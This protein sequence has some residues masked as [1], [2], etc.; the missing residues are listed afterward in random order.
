MQLSDVLK[1]VSPK[2]CYGI[3]SSSCGP[4]PEHKGAV[5]SGSGD[6]VSVSPDPEISSIHYR[7]QEVQRGGLFVAV[8]GLAADGHDFI[9]EAIKRGASAIVVQKPV[10]SGSII[11]EVENTR[12]ALASISAEFFNLPSEKLFLIGITGTNGKTTTAFLIERMFSQ[13]G[14]QAG[15]IGTLNYRYAGKT[16]QN[17]M[18]TPE[19]YDLQKILAEMLDN[20]VTHV[21]MEVSSHALD[22]FRVHRCK[23]DLAIFTNLTQDHLDY[24]HTMDEYWDCKKRL[25]TEAANFKAVEDRTLFVIN[26]NDRK[27]K[28]LIRILTS[29]FGRRCVLSVGFSGN[30]PI[31]PGQ[32]KNDLNG[33]AGEI[34]TP[35][36]AFE[37]TSPLVGRHNLENILCAT[38]AGVALGLSVNIIKDAIESVDAV[39]GRL[40]SV[41]NDYGR[42]VYVDYAHTP[43]ALEKVLLSLR[44]S[45]PG[46]IICVFG[47]GGDR[48]KAKRPRMGEVAGRLSDLAVITSDN[49]RTE[50][51]EAIIDQIMGGTKKSMSQRFTPSNLDQDFFKG[52][53]VEPDRRK[54]ILLAVKVSK[55]NDAILIAG[56]GNEPYQII[57]SKTVAFDDRK[58]AKSALSVLD[59]QSTGC[60]TVPDSQVLP[61]DSEPSNQNRVPWKTADIVEATGGKLFCGSLDRMFTGISIDSRKI[62]AE[63]L[64]LALQG[65]VHDGHRFIGG[66]IEK[67][68][69]GCVVDQK[70]LNMLPASEVRN[71]GMVCIT[72]GDTRRALGDLAAFHRRRIPVSVVAITGSNGKTTTRKM[73]SAVV[74]RRFCTLSTQ[75]NLNNDI[76]LP[77]TLLNLRSVHQ[78]AV[79]ELGMNRPGEIERLGEICLPDVGMITNIGP[80]HLEGLGSVDAVLKAKGELLATIKPD[81]TAVLNADDPRLLKL[82]DT[83]L[84]YTVLFGLSKKADITAES[85]RQHAEGL[86]FNLVLPG[87]TVSIRLQSPAMFMVSN[88]LAAASVGWVLGLSA[89]EIKEGL[90]SFQPVPGRMNIHKTRKGIHIIDDTYNANPGSMQAAIGTLTALRGKNRG[91]LIIGDMLELGDHSENLH[92]MI[93]SVAAG[94]NVAGLYVTGNFADAVVAGALE[95]GMDSETIFKGKREEILKVATKRLQ[96]GDWVLVKGSRGMAM[97]MVVEGLMAWAGNQ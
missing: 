86:S 91:F 48:D 51:P 60:Q 92:R 50:P 83:G 5:P 49:P 44:T 58:E 31:H 65:E 13:A 29:G 59:S 47:C 54:A 74:S 21:V 55:E 28:E 12:K 78:W 2:T 96:A 56:K 16:F 7:A 14:F 81:G 75:G 42:F 62:S 80:A 40:E 38:G 3:E 23:F 35:G 6:E 27:G 15:V 20:G 19:S 84:T 9:D 66:V 52:Y 76:G 70:K 11:I 68:I 10:K 79:V 71:K 30:N 41:L 85:L 89:D 1:S 95:E 63:N 64:F 93:G 87:E 8:K 32:F 25:F 33:I 67:G 36:G 94:S 43:D 90:E 88:A 17:P 46:R 73:T 53:V 24:H 22:L 4:V 39:P 61:G 57:G 72:V 82:A 97:E 37:F 18:T 77:L 34:S 45:A 26:D 69:A